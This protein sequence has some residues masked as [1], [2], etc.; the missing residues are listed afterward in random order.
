MKEYNYNIVSSS[1]E[2]SF[3]EAAMSPARSNKSSKGIPV[4]TLLQE[5]EDRTIYGSH[6]LKEELLLKDIN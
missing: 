1:K 2:N 3:E 5:L 6:F 4:S